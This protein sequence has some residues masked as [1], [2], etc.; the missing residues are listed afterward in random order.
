MCGLPI[1]LY[2]QVVQI[3]PPEAGISFCFPLFPDQARDTTIFKFTEFFVFY[4]VPVCIQIALYSVIGRRLYASTDELTTKFQ[5]RKENSCKTDRAAETIKARKGVVKMLFS[6]V[7]VYVVCYAPPQILI[8]Y[9]TFSHSPLRETW[10]FIAFVNVIAYINSAAN[11]I[12]YAIFSQNFRRNYRKC[13]CCLCMRSRRSDYR[14]ARFDSFDSR[15]L[16]GKVSST[17]TTKTSL[18]RL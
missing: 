6:S 1:A 18:S 5:M 14:R 9:N 3:P 8:F 7:I 16:G 12:L 4:F 2:N 15:G 11:P 10:S 17:A 13:L